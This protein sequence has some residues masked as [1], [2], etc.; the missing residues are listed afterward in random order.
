MYTINIP[1][2]ISVCFCWHET[3]RGGCV[4][5]LVKAVVYKLEGWWF[6]SRLT[7]RCVLG[8]DTSIPR[9]SVIIRV[10]QQQ[11]PHGDQ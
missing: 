9:S 6:Y 3:S 2:I 8:H 7:H 5:Q 4:A 11:F 10:Q 1:Q